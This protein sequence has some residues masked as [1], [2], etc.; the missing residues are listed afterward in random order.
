MT[1][2]PTPPT[3]VPPEK[4]PLNP[5]VKSGAVWGGGSG[6]LIAA[7]TAFNTGDWQTALLILLPVLI[8]IIAAY[9]K[10]DPERAEFLK[11]FQTAFNQ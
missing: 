8:Q 11:R 1:D 9:L 6:L 7:Y 10:S 5:K 3:E 2:Q 4:A